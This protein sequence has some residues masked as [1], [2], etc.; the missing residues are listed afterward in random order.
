M[1]VVVA[2]LCVEGEGAI[3]IRRVGVA[4]AVEASGLVDVDKGT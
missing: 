2:V 4:A 1:G 3:N